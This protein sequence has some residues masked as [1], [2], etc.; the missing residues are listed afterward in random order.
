MFKSILQ[1]IIVIIVFGATYVGVKYA[2]K[3]LGLTTL[4]AWKLD[5]AAQDLAATKNTTANLL[6]LPALRDAK[7]ADIADKKRRADRDAEEA[8][9]KAK[10]AKEKK[11][12]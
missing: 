10:A 2:M 1:S 6:A 7:E 8:K 12:A 4:E 9:A 11:A 5:E 3:K